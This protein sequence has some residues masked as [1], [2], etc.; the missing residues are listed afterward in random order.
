MVATQNLSSLLRDVAKE[1]TVHSFMGNCAVKMFLRNTEGKTNE[2]ASKNVFGE[3]L[4]FITTAGRSIGDRRGHEGLREGAS[5]SVTAQTLPVVAP[6]R[7]TQLAIPD[8]ERGI[9]YA[10][11][12]VHLGSRGR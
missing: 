4:G 1:E 12:L 5:I 10:E 2:Y 3:Y 6:E 8:P 11:A 7:L 9:L